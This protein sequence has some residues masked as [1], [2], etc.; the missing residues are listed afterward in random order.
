MA[1]GG[2]SRSSREHVDSLPVS[3]SLVIDGQPSTDA[4]NRAVVLRTTACGDTS[5]AF[6]SGILVGPGRVLT[7]AHVVA[8][9][10]SVAV[11]VGASSAEGTVRGY[12]WQ[13][14]L[15]VVDIQETLPL[16][17]HGPVNF[18]VLDVGDE[19]QI[20]GAATSG[21]LPFT[22]LDRTII[23]T[24][25]V[26]SPTRSRRAGYIID[27]PTQQGDSGAGIYSSDGKLVGIVFAASSESDRRSFVTSA[28]EISNFL[29]EV[30]YG[31]EFQCDPAQSKL[32]K[33]P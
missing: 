1:V 26:R 11:E 28:S 25:D 23:E 31:A 7:A 9:A 13:R 2:V 20:V 21:S 29:S 16:S 10:G 8:G 15:A 4:T 17:I 27:A 6:G 22:V 19:G 33:S 5:R 12:D 18:G 24:D 3:G 14:D 32:A 30:Q